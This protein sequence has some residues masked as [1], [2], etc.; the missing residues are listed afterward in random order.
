MELLAAIA[1][2]E[3]AMA[4]RKTT[5]RHWVR[6]PSPSRH[7]H[8]DSIMQPNNLLLLTDPVHAEPG[9]NERIVG[10]FGRSD[11][12]VN[13]NCVQEFGIITAPKD[14]ELPDAAYD[15]PG[16]KNTD[17]GLGPVSQPSLSRTRRLRLINRA[18]T[19]SWAQCRAW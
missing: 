1:R 15:M 14:V 3:R 18:E 4:L 11:W 17:G 9:P 13:Y 16:L 2:T 6:D 7:S 19:G 8:P 10:F 12:G 5:S